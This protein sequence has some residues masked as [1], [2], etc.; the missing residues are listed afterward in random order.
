MSRNTL[1]L[2]S[3]VWI[4][5]ILFTTFYN[6]ITNLFEIISYIIK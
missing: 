3:Y 6:F 5:L 4:R 1:N 2:N